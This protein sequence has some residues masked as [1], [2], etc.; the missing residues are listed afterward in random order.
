MFQRNSYL[1]LHSFTLK[2]VV[3]FFS[4]TLVTSYDH[5]WC[6]KPEVLLGTEKK[7]SSPTSLHLLYDTINIIIITA[8]IN[9]NNNNNSVEF[10]GYLLTCCLNDTSAYCTA[11][12]E[13]QI[14]R[15][16]SVNTRRQTL[17]RQKQYGQRK[18]YKKYWG[19]GPKHGEN[20][21]KLM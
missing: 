4:E 16:N 1:H 21:C 14:E 10:T 15:K 9:N 20:V 11:R 2:M 7:S 18:Q 3:V 8:Y 13:T 5:V 6:H 19:K 17:A 12:T